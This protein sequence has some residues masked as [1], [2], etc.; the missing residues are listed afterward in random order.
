MLSIAAAVSL[1]LLYIGNQG[2]NLNGPPAPKS[3][4]TMK[5][6]DSMNRVP[7]IAR[8]G[9]GPYQLTLKVDGIVPNTAVEQQVEM[10]ISKESSVENGI[11]QDNV[12]YEVPVLPISAQ[13][14]KTQ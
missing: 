5:E 8:A 6:V 12:T 3:P 11:L 9:D 1:A 7:I 13:G 10:V 2:P 4:F 14:P